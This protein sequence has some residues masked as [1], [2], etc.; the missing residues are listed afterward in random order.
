MSLGTGG[1]HAPVS[2]PCDRTPSTYSST[3][4][5]QHKV[6][7]VNTRAQAAQAELNG[8]EGA[9]DLT[10]V[11]TSTG[12]G[13]PHHIQIEGPTV[14]LGPFATAVV[15]QED[16]LADIRAAAVAELR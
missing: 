15:S 14:D 10:L 1:R 6:L 7:L 4:D 5:D 16:M 13:A 8:F 3:A 12:S 11:D 9:A 2:P